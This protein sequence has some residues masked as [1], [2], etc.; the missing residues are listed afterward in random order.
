[1]LGVAI[2]GLL[3]A[4]F[5]SIM[6]KFF[7]E[8][9]KHLRSEQTFKMQL[10]LYKTVLIQ[11]WNF[12]LLI[13]TSIALI[14]I[15]TLF[16]IRKTTIFVQL[17]VALMELHGV[18]DLCFIMYFITPYRKFIKEKIR[19]FKN[20][21]QIIKVNLIKQPTISIPNREIVEHR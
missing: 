21:N 1:M 16:E 20:P 7:I 3:A 6:P 15:I 14:C 12:L 18:F 13:L 11:G 17:L 9:A 4:I 5:V 10:M 8:R 2:A 19:C